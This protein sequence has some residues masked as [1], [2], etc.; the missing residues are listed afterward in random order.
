MIEAV[1]PLEPA[2]PPDTQGGG[3]GNATCP[4]S[5]ADDGL[6]ADPPE[7]QGGGS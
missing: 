7:N 1:Q 5:S 6:S 3:D 4:E 2:D